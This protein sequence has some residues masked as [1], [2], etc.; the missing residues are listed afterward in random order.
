MMQ[1]NDASEL[2]LDVL[3]N[4]LNP[5]SSFVSKSSIEPKNKIV[6][7]RKYILNMINATLDKNPS[8][9]IIPII[10]E[11]GVGKTYML[12]QII[13]RLEITA[14]A[15]FMDVPN[16]PK[17]FYYEVY[18]KILKA[19]GGIGRL[20]EII[21]SISEKWGAK[22]KKY[23]LFRINSS[24]QLLQ[25]A[26]ET[27][28]FQWSKNQF[29]LNQ[30]YEVFLSLTIEPERA[31]LAERWLLGEIM[32][33]EDLFY[34]GI[35]N[36]IN[37]PIIAR[38]LVKIISEYLNEGII[39]MFDDLDHNWKRFQ[40]NDEEENDYL[41]NNSKEITFFD[42]IE[43]LMDL[44]KNIYIVFTAALKNSK[45]L[46]ERFAPQTQNTI[47]KPISLLNFSTSDS[48][49]FFKNVMKK[50]CQKYQVD[51]EELKKIDEF[52]PITKKE[53]LMDFEDVSGNP[54]GLIKLFKDKLDDLIWD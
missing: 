38:E 10:G 22:E 7:N 8:G 50:F 6:P 45:N 37:N 51:R 11:S 12:W 47:S 41:I 29:E 35:E 17:D 39:I 23:G 3:K 34:L 46:L 16:K 4:H 1:E 27:K 31:A 30:I 33:R 19:I 43:E 15:I 20:R 28:R 32:D 24:D 9:A 48:K 52:Y 54:R 25:N 14:P 49:Y 21:R 42:Q 40:Y 36:S 44:T 5:F 13:L 18:I 53:I 2:F 26:M